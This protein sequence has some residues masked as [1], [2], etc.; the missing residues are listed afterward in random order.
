M[1]KTCP[2][3]CVAETIAYY[4]EAVIDRSDMCK[5]NLKCCALRESFSDSDMKLTDIITDNKTITHYG[6]NPSNNKVPNFSNVEKLTIKTTPKPVTSTKLCEGE[7][8]NGLLALFCDDVDSSA[9]CP[10]EESCCV[11]ISTTKSTLT[12]STPFYTPYTSQKVPLASNSFIQNTSFITTPL[13]TSNL[14]KCPGFCF[15]NIMA[16]FCER[17]S[18]LIQYTSTCKKGYVCCDNTRI[19]TSSKFKLTSTT[20]MINSTIISTSTI[21]PEDSRPDCVGSCIVPY[22]SFTCFSKYFP[23]SSSVSS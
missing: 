16:A 23:F 20:E 8:L 21:F 13:G 14:P 2:G 9:F 6:S 11:T 22:L 10:G 7:C 5:P 17:P 12:T 3:I 4:C 1:T 18:I 15:L 19:S